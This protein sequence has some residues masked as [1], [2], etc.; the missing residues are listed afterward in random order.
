MSGTDISEPNF[1]LRPG[2]YYSSTS[3]TDQL[4]E[5]MKEHKSNPDLAEKPF[6]A[7]YAFTAPHWPLQAPRDVREKY[8]GMYDD[9]PAALRSRR[10]DRLKALGLVE[11]SV[12]PHPVENPMAIQQWEGM[13]S[14]NKAK[15][16]RAME[17]VRQVMCL[18]KGSTPPW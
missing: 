7:Y 11:P 9:G 16:A 1:P 12:T 8:K 4:L 6:F 15:S 13:S 18:A 14:E 2:G 5:F 3:F 10:L 17:T